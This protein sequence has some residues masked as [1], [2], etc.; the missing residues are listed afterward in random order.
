M[1]NIFNIFNVF[2]TFTATTQHRWNRPQLQ[3]VTAHE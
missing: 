3:V 1:F 2:N